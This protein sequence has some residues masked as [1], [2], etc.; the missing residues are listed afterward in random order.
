[1][2]QKLGQLRQLIPRLPEPTEKQL[3]FLAL[4][5]GDDVPLEALYGGA[6]GGGKSTALLMGAL[7]YVDVPGYSALILRRTY[8]DL[9]LPGALMDMA[10][11][12]LEGSA[13]TWHDMEKTWR[14]PSGATL[15]FG[16]LEAERD[17]YRYQSAEF[18]FLAFDELTQF[19]ESQ[20]RY[21]LSR[22][23][24]PEGLP[25][26]LRVRCATNPGGIGH[27]WVKRR[28]IEE[29]PAAGRFYL[30]ATL[31][32]NPHL[33]RAAYLRSLSELDP[34]TRAQLLEGDWNVR[35]GRMF[36]REW[37]RIA[38]E[39]P[40]GVRLVRYWDLAATEPKPG[41]DPDYTAGA[42]VGLDEAGNVWICHVVRARLSPGSVEELVRQTAVIDGLA[43]PIYIEEEP[44]ASGKALIDHFQRRVLQGYTVR[45]APASGS[46]VARAQ[47]LAARAEA[48]QVYIV[49]GPWV[50]A[51]LDEVEAFPEGAHDDQVDAV[52]GAC[53]VLWALQKVGFSGVRTVLRQRKGIWR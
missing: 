39:R 38:H 48:G 6:A 28:F 23:R 26:P 16:Y 10:H 30:P 51:F 36:R 8:T 34:I 53:Q 52:A 49:N 11:E 12:W 47:P 17:K 35:S 24:K 7:L 14:F 15:T 4:D 25:V 9:A 42:L 18:T 31:D 43:V 44:G 13:A 20:Y 21:L 5:V 22:L 3:A 50:T 27:D 45:P 19:T 33:D 41:R 37:F 46:K 32:D 29:G 1:V 40:P 2:L